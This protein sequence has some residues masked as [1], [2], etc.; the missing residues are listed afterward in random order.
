[1]QKKGAAGDKLLHFTRFVEK[2][3]LSNKHYS[4][5]YVYVHS[6]DLKTMVL[7]A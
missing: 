7:R 3:V 1:L 5:Y 2:N 4:K 6:K